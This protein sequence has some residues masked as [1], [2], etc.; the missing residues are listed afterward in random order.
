MRLWPRRRASRAKLLRTSEMMI[1]GLVAMSLAVGGVF[2]VVLSPPPNPCAGVTGAV[3]SFTI[4]AYLDGYN[5]SE[6]HSGSWPIV[7]VQRCDTVVFNVINTD[8]GTHG[9]AVASYSN[10]GLELVGQDQQKLQFQATR[11]GQF[12]IYSTYCSSP[13]AHKFMLNGLLN[14]T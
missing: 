3:R 1:I 5:G 14:V 2:A 8:T 9:F 10:A 7:N 11:I 6:Y 4:I 13:T 12:R